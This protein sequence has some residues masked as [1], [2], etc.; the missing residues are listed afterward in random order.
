MAL[1]DDMVK[2]GNWLFRYR[3]YLPLFMVALLLISMRNYTFVSVNHTL[4]V[5]WELFCFA[6]AM[7]G[8]GIRAHVIGHT[9][10]GTSG[11]NTSGQIADT[12]N[13]TGFYSIMRHPLY[14]GNFF[15]WM[16]V[17]LFV[18]QWAM[19]V[20]MIMVYFL[21]Y[22]RIIM[23]EEDYLRGKFGNAFE[24]WAKRTHCV[25]PS[26]GQWEKPALSFS[27][28]NVLKREY[29]GLFAVIVLFNLM[30]FIG[31]YEVTKTIVLDPMWLIIL[32]IGIV[33]YLVLRTLKKHTHY[34]H[35]EGR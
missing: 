33:L 18:H 15:M 28:K 3:S 14:V 4:D 2:N 27:F 11:R 17:A 19:S 16:G 29:S 22:E 10:K 21:Y 35:V 31:D 34:L 8:L 20:V 30:E 1:R 6:V 25:I 12:L 26:F 13:T 9:P 32:G 5:Y 24:V 7:F 23:A